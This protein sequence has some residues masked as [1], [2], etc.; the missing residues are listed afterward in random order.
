MPGLMSRV[1]AQRPYSLDQI[2]GSGDEN[3]FPAQAASTK[4]APV[5]GYTS[6][7]LSLRAESGSG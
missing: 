4:P 7:S 5:L 2:R 6:D 1:P 3:W